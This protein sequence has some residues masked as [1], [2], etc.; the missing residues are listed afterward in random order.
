[1]VD[2]S[3]EI[4]K[5]CAKRSFGGNSDMKGLKSTVK[6]LLDQGM[7]EKDLN[8]IFRCHI[9]TMDLETTQWFLEELGAKP[10]HDPTHL[11]H[12]L[13]TDPLG[14]QGCL[15]RDV[16]LMACIYNCE[17]EKVELLLK[18]GAKVVL[19]EDEP[20]NLWGGFSINIL[21]QTISLRFEARRLNDR[22]NLEMYF[23]A[24]KLLIKYDPFCMKKEEFGVDG[25]SPI[26]GLKPMEVAL[27]VQDRRNMMPSEVT[28]S[29]DYS[30]LTL[31]I[32]NGCCVNGFDNDES[33]Y[34]PMHDA[35]SSGDYAL[36]QFIACYEGFDPN[37]YFDPFDLNYLLFAFE[38][39][40]DFSLILILLDV[41]VCPMP[42]C[43]RGNRFFSVVTENRNE[44]HL[45]LR[46]LFVWLLDSEYSSH[47]I[48]KYFDPLPASGFNT[49]VSNG[50]DLTSSNPFLVTAKLFWKNP[51]RVEILDWLF[52]KGVD[53]NAVDE[54][55]QTDLIQA[56]LSAFDEENISHGRK[57][58]IIC[59]VCQAVRG[60]VIWRKLYL[61]AHMPGPST[62]LHD[63]MRINN[64]KN[65][66]AALRNM[67]D[68]EIKDIYGKSLRDYATELSISSV[69][70]AL[71]LEDKIHVSTVGQM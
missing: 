26:D 35:L 24:I 45:L 3:S 6:T 47:A 70:E 8:R 14:I 51:S 42:N 50:S 39:Q 2:A 40:V 43:M 7:Q 9:T 46:K 59:S 37:R 61:A 38:K 30:V 1:M 23:K 29:A 57:D 56:F 17:I 66:M 5:V 44:N 25:F 63:A 27:G 71:G 28:L 22:A 49:R 41:G 10:D 11:W 18:H 58:D 21:S 4:D 13:R 31:L 55:G 54:K 16:P 32:E 48:M 62:V 36:V 67:I 15:R 20:M 33:C 52:E 53:P 65:E 12:A 34:A 19:Y 64:N 69:I 68:F 60:L